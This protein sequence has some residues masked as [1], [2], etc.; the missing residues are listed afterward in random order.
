MRGEVKEAV[1]YCDGVLQMRGNICVSK[2]GDLIIH[3]LEEIHFSRYS[4]HL[5][6]ANKYDELR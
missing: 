4:I 3:I 2:V 1:L 5:G 6:V